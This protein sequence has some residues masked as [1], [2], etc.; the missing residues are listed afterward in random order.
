M[1]N[2][3]G[4]PRSKS[5]ICLITTIVTGR[6]GQREA[7]LTINQNYEKIRETNEPS[8]MNKNRKVELNLHNSAQSINCPIATVRGRVAPKAANFLDF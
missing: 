6:I 7:L 5:Q 2:K 4:R 8:V 3:I 1:I